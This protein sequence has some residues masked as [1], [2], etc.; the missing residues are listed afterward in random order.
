MHLNVKPVRGTEV[1]TR[2]QQQTV[3]RLWLH[4]SASILLGKKLG[5]G[6][7][8]CMYENIVLHVQPQLAS[9]CYVVQNPR[10]A[11]LKSLCVSKGKISTQR[12]AWRDTLSIHMKMCVFLAKLKGQK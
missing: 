2:K 7:E 12:L 1:Y 11:A 3:L 5:L 10:I 4:D 9:F 6:A 8:S